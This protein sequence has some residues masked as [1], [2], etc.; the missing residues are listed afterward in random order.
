VASDAAA[1]TVHRARPC[2]EQ[3]SGSAASAAVTR[4]LRVP[5]GACETS[6]RPAS[7]PAGAPRR[8]ATRSREPAFAHGRSAIASNWGVGTPRADGRGRPYRRPR[9][10]PGPK[11]PPRLRTSSLRLRAASCRIFETPGGLSPRG[12]GRRPLRALSSLS[13]A[14]PPKTIPARPT[15]CR[16]STTK[17]KPRARSAA[18]PPDARACR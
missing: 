13:R 9:A 12:P 5:A 6:R 18:R 2:P 17:T 4:P 10:L 1:T 16:G 14:S 7:S 8:A 3:G 11:V 15:T